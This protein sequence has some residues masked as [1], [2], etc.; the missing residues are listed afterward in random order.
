MLEESVIPADESGFPESY[1]VTSIADLKGD[2]T[3]EIVAA[4]LAWENS[5]VTVYEATLETGARRP[6]QRRLRSLIVATANR[7]WQTP[8][9]D[10]GTTGP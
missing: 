9:T 3:M 8:S 6:A 7:S 2:R 5:S 1:A 10:G 4:G